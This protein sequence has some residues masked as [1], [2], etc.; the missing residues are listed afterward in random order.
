[1]EENETLKV[2][3]VTTPGKANDSHDGID[4]GVDS[5]APK[6]V[7]VE[8]A[9]SLDGAS[10]TPEKK[11]IPVSKSTDSPPSSSSSGKG[12]GGTPESTSSSVQLVLPEKMAKEKHSSSK[13]MVKEEKQT[14][15][16]VVGLSNGGQ[17][18]NVSNEGT[19]E[20]K[21]VLAKHVSG[22]ENNDGGEKVDDTKSA[23]NAKP[24]GKTDMRI[25]LY[26]LVPTSLILLLSL[27]KYNLSTLNRHQKEWEM[28]VPLILPLDLLEWRK[29][30]PFRTIRARASD[31]YLKMKSRWRRLLA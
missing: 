9:M 13:E 12:T 19:N 7:V 26:G 4:S 31:P 15:N 30:L 27:F 3:S 25:T 2:G 1:V 5:G 10:E 28:V 22:N 29:S 6:A 8:G 17:L 24:G 20:K 18:A 14:N 21:S 23:G 16:S 11:G